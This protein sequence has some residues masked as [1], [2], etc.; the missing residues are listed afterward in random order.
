MAEPGPSGRRISSTG[1]WSQKAGPRTV[2]KKKTTSRCRPA[3]SS[4]GL[5]SSHFCRRARGRPARH[6]PRPQG[7]L[8]SEAA[9]W[10]TRPRA[11]APAPDPRRP[12]TRDPGLAARIPPQRRPGQRF[13]A[14]A[15]ES[16]RGPGS[17]LSPSPARNCQP[18]HSSIQP[19]GFQFLEWGERLWFTQ[20][21]G[22][23]SRRGRR[24]TVPIAPSS[25]A[26]GPSPGTEPVGRLGRAFLSL[27]WSQHRLGPSA[28]SGAPPSP[29]RT[30]G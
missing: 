21:R 16:G 2:V 5:A 11:R 13:P 24:P 6:L 7:S 18:P 26:R 28:P 20:S 10:P 3:S 23:E 27:G 4:L 25:Q 14:V 29:G 12:Q 1:P 9:L 17:L 8:G 22:S 15:R 19:P 30:P